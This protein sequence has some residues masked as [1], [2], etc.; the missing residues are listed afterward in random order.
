[1]PRVAA[2]SSAVATHVR[3]RMSPWLLVLALVG[4]SPVVADTGT[5]DTCASFPGV[6]AACERC[7]RASADVG[8][9]SAKGVGKASGRA[10]GRVCAS[11]GG[12]DW[13]VGLQQND[14]K[15]RLPGFQ[16]IRAADALSGHHGG[17]T[18]VSR[19]NQSNWPGIARSLAPGIVR[20]VSEAETARLCALWKGEHSYQ[21]FPT[22]LGCPGF[23]A[24]EFEPPCANV[25]GVYSVR[26]ASI[27]LTSDPT[28]SG[29]VYDETRWFRVTHSQ[30]PPKVCNARRVVR[31]PAV[32]VALSVYPTAVGHFVP[33]QLVGVL[34]LHAHIPPDVPI[35]VADAGTTRRYLQPLFDNGAL[36][37]SRIRF[38]PLRSDGLVVQADRVYTPTNSHF[39]NVMGGDASYRNARQ[40][41]SPDGPLPA[42]QRVDILL[43]DRG[44]GKPRSLINNEAV[45]G[46]LQEMVAAGAGAGTGDASAAAAVTPPKKLAFRVISWRPHAKNATADVEAFRRAAMIVAPHGAGLSNMLFAAEATPVIELCY[47]RTTGGMKCP[48]MYAAMAANLHLP[49]WVVT[50]RGGYQTPMMADLAQLRLAVG[51]ALATM[52]ALRSSRGIS[53][54]S[55]SSG[56]N[57]GEQVA[58][59][60]RTLHST[61]CHRAARKGGAGGG[62]R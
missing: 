7:K 4:A 39:S 22:L 23:T 28:N 37:P 31:L 35:I 5:T 2:A 15:A 55:S 44:V 12:W 57:V 18:V 33:E 51:Q 10:L 60:V 41:F 8:R 32:G 27:D 48:A 43:V 56:G 19:V 17:V 24:R 1:M 29:A 54:I 16:I 9:F 3:R 49:Y 38:E 59:L 36:A 58:S 47:D 21:S 62:Q 45:L 34:L 26:C 25:A 53:G 42:S 52:R 11:T 40:A 46:L 50:A 20:T 61:K 14:L 6:Q 13:Q 30:H